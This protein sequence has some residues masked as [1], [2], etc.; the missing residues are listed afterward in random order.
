VV[1]LQAAHA[2]DF[3]R[4]KPGYQGQKAGIL[5]VGDVTNLLITAARKI[6]AG[7]VP[8]VHRELTQRLATLLTVAR[9]QVAAF[10]ETMPSDL[11]HALKALVGERHGS[12][13]TNVVASGEQAVLRL[14]LIGQMEAMTLTGENVLPAGL[15]TRALLAVVALLSPRPV[16]HGR[17]AELLWSKQPE[18]EARASLRQE[19]H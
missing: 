6:A 16:L 11:H 7:A 14:R 12:G 17:L 5:A 19:I 4:Q 2:L 13:E 8:P 3:K 9:T 18:E 10:A 1:S 15:K